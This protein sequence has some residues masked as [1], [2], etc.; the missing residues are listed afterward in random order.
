MRELVVTGISRPDPKSYFSPPEKGFLSWDTLIWRFAAEKSYWLCTA[1]ADPHAMPVWGIW[2]DSAFK[3]STS[4]NSR[5]AKNLKSNPRATVHLGDTEAVLSLECSAIELTSLADQ[6]AFCDEYNP[7]YRWH[8]SNPDDVAGGLFALTP[9]TAFAWA[10][11]D[12]PVF[13]DTGTRF[14]LKVIE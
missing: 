3:F 9:H 12:E 13:N 8:F 10:S 6:Q 7:K 14:S 4:P 5:K 2:H 1:G 11:G